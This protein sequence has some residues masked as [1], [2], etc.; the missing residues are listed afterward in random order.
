MVVLKAVGTHMKYSRK[1]N[2]GEELA[3]NLCF[4]VFPNV[5]IHIVS[6]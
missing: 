2:D 6:C 3:G 1:L 4:L 5:N